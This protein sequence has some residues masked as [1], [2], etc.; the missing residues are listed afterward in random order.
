MY[1]QELI[2]QVVFIFFL[3]GVDFWPIF[4]ITQGGPFV[5]DQKIEN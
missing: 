4:L 2:N 3:R 5:N 1:F